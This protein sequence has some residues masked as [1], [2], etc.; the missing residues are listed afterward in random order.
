MTMNK[1]PKSLKKPSSPDKLYIV[2]KYIFAKN[3]KGAIMKDRKTSVHEVWVDDDW[4]K[5][6]QENLA[7]A[8]GFD[9]GDDED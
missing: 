2:R 5:G 7:N 3:A 8:I 1:K 9:A 4:K 6:Q